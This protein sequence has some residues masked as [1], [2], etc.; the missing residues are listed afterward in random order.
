M[1]ADSRLTEFVLP[2]PKMI[3]SPQTGVSTDIMSNPKYWIFF[4]FLSLI[5]NNSSKQR[6]SRQSNK[7]TLFYVVVLLYSDYERLFRIMR[8]RKSMKIW[9]IPCIAFKP[10]FFIYVCI[11]I[12]IAL[13][14][15]LCEY[16]IFHF[17]FKSKYKN[18]TFKWN[19]LNDD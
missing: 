6:V 4:F 16:R 2:P 3:P 13:T 7:K 5:I 17:N 18:F 11:K 1:S 12:W 15:Q 14:V 9:K 10:H 8:I 19:V